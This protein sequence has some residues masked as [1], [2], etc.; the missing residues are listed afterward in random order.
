MTAVA[1]LAERGSWVAIGA[2][3]I[4]VVWAVGLAAWALKDHSH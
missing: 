3:M 4:I 2:W 1:M